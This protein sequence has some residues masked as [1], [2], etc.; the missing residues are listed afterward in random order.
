MRRMVRSLAWRYSAAR[1]DRNE[2]LEAAIVE[3]PES[4]DAYLIYGDWLLEN[5]DPLGELVTVQATLAKLRTRAGNAKEKNALARREKK[6]LEAAEDRLGEL[7]ALEHTWSFGFLEALVLVGPS[8]RLYE[9]VLAAPAARFLRELDIEDGTFALVGRYGVPRALRKLALMSGRGRAALGPM[10]PA[11]AK[12]TSIREL[13]VQGRDVELGHIVFPALETFALKSALTNDVLESVRTADWPRLH[14]IHLEGDADPARLGIL[15]AEWAE[16]ETLRH[17]GIT[18]LETGDRLLESIL[19]SGL[20][21]QLSSLDLSN[22]AISD[23]GV[24]RILENAEAFER[25]ESFNLSENEISP[26][27]ERALEKRFELVVD[28]EEQFARHDPDEA[29][30]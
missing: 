14:S 24:R 28:V 17:V 6:L 10:E 3:A 25:L 1:M 18:G 9:S 30:D 4:P 22:T 7:R 23:Q 16:R 21:A 15:F 27:N 11:M 19:A 29:D 2:E 8:A 26:A 5:G 20:L 12:L 13:T